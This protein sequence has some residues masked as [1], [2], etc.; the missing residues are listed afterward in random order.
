MQTSKKILLFGTGDLAM[1]AKLYFERDY[2]YEV[3][4]FTVDRS[5]MNDTVIDGVPVIPFD[6]IEEYFPPDTHD[7][8]VCLIYND[9]NRLR[10]EKCAEAKKKGYRLASFISP[11]SYVDETSVIGEHAFIF[12]DNTVQP[13]V[14]IGDNCILWSGNHVGHHSR[15]GNNVFVSSHVVISG[16]CHVGD[17][18]FIGVNTSLANGTVIGK[19]SWISHGAVISGIVHANS[20]VKSPVSE[21][22]PLNEPALK[23]ALERAKK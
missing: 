8:H 16:H 4:A 3:A 21:I 13:F 17:N 15:I 22:V 18:T 10:A 6:V 2:G 9:M 7:M 20:F 5:Y 12:E 14:E 11:H 1:I 19:E 23:R